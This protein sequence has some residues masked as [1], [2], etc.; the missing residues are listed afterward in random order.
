MKVQSLGN[1]AARGVISIARLGATFLTLQGYP[2]TMRAAV[3]ARQGTSLKI[4]GVTVLTSYDD[5]DLHAAG[6]R[7]GVSELVEARAL[8]AHALGV[9]GLVCAAEEVADVRAIVG[10]QMMLV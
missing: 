2:Q 7:F 5:S 1:A 4:L 10:M 8:Q 9:D 6:Y 3:E